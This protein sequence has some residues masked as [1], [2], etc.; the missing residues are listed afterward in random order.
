VKAKTL[1]IVWCYLYSGREQEAW[2]TLAE[3]WPAADVDR[4][5]AAIVSAR[6]RGISAQ[7]NG[8]S[9]GIPANRTKRVTI[10]DAASA[11]ANKSEVIPPAQILLRR[12]PPSGPDMLQSELML[13]LVIDSAGKVRSAHGAGKTKSVDAE[14]IYAATGWKFIPAFKAGRAVASRLRLAVSLRR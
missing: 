1:E 12:P 6:A 9:T 7:V 13:E 3:M 2:R 10:F 8:V 11:S 14:L 5:R 4:I